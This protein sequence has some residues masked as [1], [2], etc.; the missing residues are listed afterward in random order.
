[1]NDGLSRRREDPEDHDTFLVQNGLV[2]FVLFE[3]S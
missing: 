1:V 2:I 3:A